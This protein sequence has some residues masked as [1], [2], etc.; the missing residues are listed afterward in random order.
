LQNYLQSVASA[1]GR[2]TAATT[3]T[4]ITSTPM[5]GPPVTYQV[6]TP[7]P[8]VTDLAGNFLSGSLKVVSGKVV[9][10]ATVTS[11]NV[12][13]VQTDTNGDGTFDQSQTST[14]AGLQSLL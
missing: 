10:L 6:S 4:V 11:F 1:D 5:E 3:A 7:V 8:M 12:I 9:L 2:V 13:T 14:V